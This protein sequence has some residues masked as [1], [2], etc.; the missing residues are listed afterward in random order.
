[1]SKN[2]EKEEVYYQ[3]EVYTKFFDASIRFVIA[4]DGV[5]S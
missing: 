2:K 4:K 3:F 1:M 5:F